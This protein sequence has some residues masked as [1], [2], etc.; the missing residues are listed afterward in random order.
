MVTQRFGVGYAVFS[1]GNGI[2]LSLAAVLT[3]LPFIHLLAVSLSAEGPA[4]G[5]LVGLLPEGFNLRA[6]DRVVREGRLIRSFV[7]SFQRVVLGTT[8]NVLLTLLTAYALHFNSHTFP[9]RRVYATFF[10]FT[11]IF[12]AGLVPGYILVR[13]LGLLNSMW[14][15][16]LPT[17]VPVFLVLLVMNFFRHIPADIYASARIDG[18]GHVRILFRILA[19]MSVPS[20]AT[21]TLFSMIFHWNSWFDGLIFISHVDKQPL[22]T[23]LQALL[24]TYDSFVSLIEAERAASVGQRSLMY[25]RLLVAIVP[26]AIVYPFLQKYFR[27][28]I[29]LG[30]VKG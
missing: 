11:M 29:V 19:P 12:D 6:Y 18:A 3:V 15:L 28:G 27:K 21:V 14:A 5:G 8:L 1:V 13:S 7:V 23:Y 9:G 2:M 26:I 20:I 25:A 24:N 10:L 17:A 22:Q 16:V 30:S 4:S